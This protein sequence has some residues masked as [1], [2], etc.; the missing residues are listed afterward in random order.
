MSARNDDY[1]PHRLL[2]L[3]D[4]AATL[5][6]SLK[7]IRR[8]IADRQIAVIRNGRLV[9]VHPEDLERY[10]RSRRFGDR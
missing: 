5:G 4:T 7:T 6:C 10:I 2:T 9:R 3:Q 8:R 1:L